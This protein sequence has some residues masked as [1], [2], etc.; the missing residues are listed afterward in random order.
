MTRIHIVLAISILCILAPVANAQTVAPGQLFSGSLL[1]VR[2]P[3]SEGWK[4]VSS[5]GAGMA[6]ARSGASSNESYVAQVSLFT[7]PDSK[8]R[9]E[10]IALIKRGV[11]NDTP[12]ERFKSLEANYEYIEQ[13]GYP[14][15]RFTGVTEDTKAKTSFFSRE[16]LKLQVH[17]LYCRHPKRQE[18]GFVIGFSHRGATLDAELDV[19]ARAFIEGVQ[20][21]EK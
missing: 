12:P 11:E 2:A 10:F 4:V 14:C 6:F 7:L 9:D 15:I 5:S 1:N 13:R 17:S 3:N 8:D 21:P 19:Q 20:V 18:A 16:S